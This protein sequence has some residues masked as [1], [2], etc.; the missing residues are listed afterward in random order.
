MGLSIA[1]SGGIVL[2]GMTYL[3]LVL[4][5]ISDNITVITITST[6]TAELE[7]DIQKTSIDLSIDSPPGTD[8]TFDF[9]LTNTDILKLWDFEKFDVIVT[10]DSSGTTYTETLTYDS[11]CPPTAGEWCIFDWTD[12]VLDPEILNTDESIT[13]RA[14]VNNSLQNNR[15][16]IIIVSTPNGVVATTTTTV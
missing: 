9:V 14:E 2:F 10:Y 3:I 13:I 16:L 1:I 11:A 6:E 15:D 7:N 5:G 12:D 4:S 8:S